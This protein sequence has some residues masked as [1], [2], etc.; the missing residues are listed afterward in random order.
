MERHGRA[1]ELPVCTFD[2][3]SPRISSYEVHEWI[4]EQLHVSEATVTM[5]QIDGLRRQVFIKFVDLQYAQEILQTKKISLNI[6][7]QTGKYHLSA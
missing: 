2:T 4:Q 3:Q 7:I 6:N 5:I 1:T